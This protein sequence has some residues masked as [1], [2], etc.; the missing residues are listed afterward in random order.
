MLRRI[1]ILTLVAAAGLG[2]AQEEALGTWEGVIGPDMLD[3]GF[4]VTLEGPVDA[5]TGIMSIPVQ[6]LI[7]FP[8]GDIVIGNR[9]VS[10]TMPGVPGDPVFDGTIE[11]D[12]ASGTFTQGGAEIPFTMERS[13]AE[14][15]AAGLNRPQTPEPPFPYESVDLT[16]SSLDEDITLAATLTIPE[17]EGPFPAVLFLTGTGPQDRDEQIFG[18]RPFLILSD[19][20]TRAGFVTLR[21]DDRGVG[22]STGEDHRAGTADLLNDALAGVQLLDSR[23]EVDSSMIGIVGHSHGGQMAPLVAAES[24][25]VGFVIS[26]AGPSVSGMDVLRLQNRLVFEHQM[27]GMPAEVVEAA[28][29]DQIAMLDAIHGHFVAGDMEAAAAH[30]ESVI[31]QQVAAVPEDQQPSEE[32]IQALVD[33][34]VSGNVNE[35]MAGFMTFEPTES[36]SQLTVPYLGIYGGKDIQVDAEQNA[37]PARDALE[38]A[39]NG[40][41]T[42]VVMDG[43][44]HLMQ[45]AE[46]GYPDEYGTIEITMD[47]E[48]IDLIVDWAVTRFR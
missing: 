20:L 30:L 10:W 34:Q 39:G 43:L 5:P 22:G 26:I 19:A 24:D 16:Y 32:E 38:A 41:Y 12:T 18:H 42:V 6:G 14:E 44:N 21:A 23:P 3:L 29:A 17:G 25:L 47:Q 27:A 31:R 1:A 15:V 4:N 11:G 36:L 37:Q 48:V 8:V 7:D 33:M 45:P 13:S 28:V 46:T 9:T 2:T 40:D 35:A